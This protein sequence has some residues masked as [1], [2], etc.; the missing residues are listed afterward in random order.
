MRKTMMLST[1]LSDVRWNKGKDGF[2]CVFTLFLSL[3]RT[4]SDDH[5][6]LVTS[7]IDKECQGIITKEYQ[8][9]SKISA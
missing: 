5:I 6:G 4:A 9:R 1:W 8:K 3:R 7:K 2:F